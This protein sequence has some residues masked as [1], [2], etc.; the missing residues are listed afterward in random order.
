M[1]KVGTR[2]EKTQTEGLP[3]SGFGEGFG[4]MNFVA[5]GG[6]PC[7]STYAFHLSGLQREQPQ[8]RKT[9]FEHPNLCPAASAF[10]LF[11]RTIRSR[12]GEFFLLLF[13]SSCF[14]LSFAPRRG[15]RGPRPK[16]CLDSTRLLDAF[17]LQSSAVDRFSPSPRGP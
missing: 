11:S 12:S 5:R 1:C 13:V 17:L 8:A 4:S 15:F 9:H 16:L 10:A 14:I 6:R 7:F 3:G 2:E